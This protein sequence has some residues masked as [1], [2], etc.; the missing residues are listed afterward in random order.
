MIYQWN[1]YV[2]CL[3]EQRNWAC[4]VVGLSALSLWLSKS[5]LNPSFGSHIPITV[6]KIS[7]ASIIK[8]YTPLEPR[9]IACSVASRTYLRR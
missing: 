4:G 9:H 3:I 7:Y 6:F 5:V 1:V 8:N 2:S